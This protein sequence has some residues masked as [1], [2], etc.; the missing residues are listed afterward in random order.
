L[1][2][3]N[4]IMQDKNV[5]NINQL[6]ELI[7][8]TKDFEFKVK[9]L[10]EKY[11]WIEEVLGR[12]KY[13]S[14]KKKEKTIIK[15]YI[16]TITGL[17]RAQVTRLIQRKK[18][19]G[20]IIPHYGKRNKFKT[21]YTTTDIARLIETDNCHNRLSGQATKTIFQ[22]EYNIFSRKEF[23]RI[24]DISISHIYNLRETRQYESHTLTVAKTKAVSVP[25]GKRIK[26]SP[27]GRPGFLRVDTVHQGDLDKEKGVY[28]I[29]LV[30]EIIQWEIIGCV[31][32]ISEKFL[33]PLLE[34]LLEQ[35]PF[36]IINFHSDNGS[37]CI[38][39]IVSKL[40][41]K[42]LISQTKSRARH[43][44]DN[45]LV[46]TKNG[47]LIRK[48]IGY[49]FINKKEASKINEF[50]RHHFN[51]YLNFHHPCG[52]AK[53]IVNVKGKIKKIY[54]QEN[55]TTPYEKLKSLINAEK[56]LKENISFEQLDKIAYNKS[57]NQFAEEMKKVKVELFKNFK[58][59]PQF[60]TFYA[61]CAIQDLRLIP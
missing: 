36:V 50:Y 35:F 38:N 8:V 59:K 49:A 21:I 6:K 40:L 39:K 28:H 14:L 54:P 60:P 3:M 2:N 53:E 55:Y 19:L 27:Y 7:K 42:L 34:E 30:D 57:D 15:E 5:N 29:N 4:I 43:S 48:N 25:I 20:I 11:Q 13:F 56:Y 9:S 24:K 18:K 41:N 58:H 46:E 32:G 10:K 37:E 52:F 61:S 1:R 51:V 22:R 33:Q 45:G 26:P 16:E 44:N 47:S 31:E 17:K 12:F 23:E